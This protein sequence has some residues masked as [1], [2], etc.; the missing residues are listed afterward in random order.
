MS[1]NSEGASFFFDPAKSTA[2]LAQV[3]SAGF[4]SIVIDEFAGLLT[5]FDLAASMSSVSSLRIVMTHWAGVV[6]PTVAAKQLAWLDA[7]S[8]GRL[9]LR[10]LVDGGIEGGETAAGHVAAWQQTDEYLVLLKRLWSNEE[11]FDHEGPFYS[12]RGGFVPHKSLRGFEIPIR[13]GGLSGTA[14]KVAARHADIFE[15]AP[16][17]PAEVHGLIARVRAAAV[18]YGRAEKIRFA[19]PVRFTQRQRHGAAGTAI[20]TEAVQLPGLSPQAAV[21]MLAYA[22]AGVEEFMI[23][24]RWGPEQIE[25]FGREV[26]PLVKNSLRR[27]EDHALPPVSLLSGWRLGYVPGAPSNSR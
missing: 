24:D 17:S 7:T 25:R 1:S 20:A 2:T 22:E 3:E 6:A 12:I 14:L 10:M 13:M 11:P 27:K 4:H 16:G 23:V 26:A 18:E 15:L 21:S 19:L 8:G 9:A 5:N